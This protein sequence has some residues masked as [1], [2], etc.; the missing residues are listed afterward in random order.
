[1]AAVVGLAVIAMA[2]MALTD[3]GLGLIDKDDD[4][5][6][7]YFAVFALVLGDALFAIFPGETTLN[8]A[9]V[10]ASDGE[11]DLGFVILAGFLGAWVG[12]NVLYWAARS[13]PALHDQVQKAQEDERFKRGI[14]LFAKSSFV[15]VVVCRFLPFVR[16]AVIA[17]MGALPM[18]YR[19]FLLAVTLGD[20]LWASYTC[21][22]AYFIGTAL[23]DF[24]I[25][26]VAIACASSAVI[27]GGG[28]FLWRRTH[29]QETTT[30]TATSGQLS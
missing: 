26:S 24:P 2:V 9:S 8:T 6:G 19:R 4:A 5:F 7:T 18:P 13:V 16:W 14:E 3:A 30:P 29:T 12:D 28:F 11:L 22:M 27:L 21:L 15:L 23:A 1:V 25:A 20:L 17:G 10:L